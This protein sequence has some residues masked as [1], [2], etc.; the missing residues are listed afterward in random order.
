MQNLFTL[1]PIGEIII[2]YKHAIGFLMTKPAGLFIYHHLCKFS[3]LSPVL[4][5]K[6]Y[7]K[8]SIFSNT[9]LEVISR[10]YIFDNFVVTLDLQF[11]KI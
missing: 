5:Q 9:S 3:A 10:M 1:C 6:I 4:P 2:L 11:Y 7:V 8:L